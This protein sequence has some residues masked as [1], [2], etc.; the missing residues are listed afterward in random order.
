[1]LI[2]LGL[3]TIAF[4]N[5]SASDALLWMALSFFF[6]VLESD[7]SLDEQKNRQN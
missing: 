1:M 2:A 3:G 6:W 7:P 5:H 4:G